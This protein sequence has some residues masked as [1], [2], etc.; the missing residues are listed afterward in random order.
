MQFFVYS[1]SSSAISTSISNLVDRPQTEHQKAINEILGELTS[2]EREL[3][4]AVIYLPAYDQR[5][6]TQVCNAQSTLQ[7]I[8][9]MSLL[10][11][12]SPSSIPFLTV[13]L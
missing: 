3:Q 9:A 1:F 11:H 8:F 13:L 10:G 6:Y 5:S 2:L 7:L 4:D 12:I